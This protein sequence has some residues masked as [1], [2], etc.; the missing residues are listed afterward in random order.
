MQITHLTLIMC[1]TRFLDP[2]FF[3]N[4]PSSMK[5]LVA[6]RLP[7]ITPE[8]SKTLMGTLD[9]IGFNHYTTLYVR[10]DR[11]RIE[12]LILQDAYSDAAVITTCKKPNQKLEHH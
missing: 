1:S 11:R 8:M 6:E 7:Q 3:G 4:Y 5:S 10:N 2:I 12:K 9:F